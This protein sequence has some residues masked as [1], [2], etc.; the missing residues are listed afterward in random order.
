M[1]AGCKVPTVRVENGPIFVGFNE[2]YDR[3]IRAQSKA[4]FEPTDAATLEL[5]MKRRALQ[6][7]F[8]GNLDSW[9][10]QYQRKINCEWLGTKVEMTE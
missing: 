10:K 6:H 8:L 3:S 1:R 7:K 9:G 2:S 5:I 4:D